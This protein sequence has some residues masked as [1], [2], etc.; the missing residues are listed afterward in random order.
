MEPFRLFRLNDLL[1]TDSITHFSVTGLLK[2]TSNSFQINLLQEMHHNVRSSKIYYHCDG[3][4]VLLIGCEPLSDSLITHQKALESQS[5]VSISAQFTGQVTTTTARSHCSG[6]LPTSR[7]GF[8]EIGKHTGCD[9]IEERPHS[10]GW[11]L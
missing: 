9:L 7:S 4:K 11:I 2:Q 5:A 1:S 3:I 8:L 10:N 6:K